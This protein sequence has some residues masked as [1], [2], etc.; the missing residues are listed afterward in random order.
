MIMKLLQTY[1]T[2]CRVGQSGAS[3]F[4]FYSFSEGLTSEE[5]FEIEKIGNYIAPLNL[6]SN[7]S[8]EDI[9]SLFPVSFNY[10]KLKSGRV[11]V[12]QSVALIQD[13]SGRPGNFLSHAYILE[14]GNFPFF[15]ILLF[16]SSS[17]RTN[18]TSDEWNTTNYPF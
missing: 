18:L 1:Y 15:P 4:Q 12:L 17:F 16:K 5:L 9:D 8:N 3:G 7:P 13:Y 11:G 2:S 14:S 10:F 6:P